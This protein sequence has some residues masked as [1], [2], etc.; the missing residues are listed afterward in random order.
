MPRRLKMGGC[1]FWCPTRHLV[2]TGPGIRPYDD[3]SLSQR[4]Q[5]ST[6]LIDEL[7]VPPVMPHENVL[8][9]L[10]RPCSV[11]PLLPYS[12]GSCHGHHHRLLAHIT[13]SAPPRTIASQHVRRLKIETAGHLDRNTT[14]R[15]Q[16]TT[17][18]VLRTNGLCVR[19]CRR[20]G[21][22]HAA[23]TY[24]CSCTVVGRTA[25]RSHKAWLWGR[26]AVPCHWSMAYG[27]C[28]MDI[29]E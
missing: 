7:R 12:I 20:A 6:S 2:R 24:R 26:L 21:N 4:S 29:D 18:N 9:P 27:A 25:R 14:H 3:E 23:T 1:C 19:I 8:G 10:P 22:Y 15:V 5:L 28:M 16:T 13:S 17:A 11:G